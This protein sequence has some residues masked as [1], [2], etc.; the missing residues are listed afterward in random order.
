MACPWRLWLPHQEGWADPFD[1]RP[2]DDAT[3]YPSSSPPIYSRLTACPTCAVCWRR[4][5]LKAGERSGY[6]EL[7]DECLRLVDELNTRWKNNAIVNTPSSARFFAYEADGFGNHTFMDDANVPS[8]LACPTCN[9]PI[10]GR[11]LGAA[12]R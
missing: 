5:V 10:C 11:S 4:F 7:G 8:L 9:R 6:R 2:S 1:V 12:C 3:I